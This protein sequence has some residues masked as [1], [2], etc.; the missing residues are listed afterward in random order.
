MHRG[1]SYLTY[2]LENNLGFI[3]VLGCSWF[4]HHLHPGLILG[5]VF[6]RAPVKNMDMDKFFL[7]MYVQAGG[8]LPTKLLVQ[9]KRCQLVHAFHKGPYSTDW[10][11]F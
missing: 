1:S 7:D 10:L 6:A 3:V 5:K 4:G 2:L 9:K 8:L 11:C